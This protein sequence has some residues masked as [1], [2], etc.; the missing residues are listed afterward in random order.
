MRTCKP[1][2]SSSCHHKQPAWWSCGLRCAA[3]QRSPRWR[4]RWQAPQP[5]PLPT[6]T[7]QV[8]QLPVKDWCE[9]FKGLGMEAD[10]MW[11]ALRQAARQQLGSC[12]VS[13]WVLHAERRRRAAGPPRRP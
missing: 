12:R 7:L 4:C 1:C 2:A 10:D 6:P 8:L 11:K 9:F 13:L 5:L 3:W